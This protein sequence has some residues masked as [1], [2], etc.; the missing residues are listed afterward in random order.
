MVDGRAQEPPAEDHP[1][2]S[3]AV[4]ALA[5]HPSRAGWPQLLPA[6][7]LIGVPS[8]AAVY[9][10]TRLWN[11]DITWFDLILS[12]VM[13]VLTGLGITLGFHRMLAHGS[14]H[15]RRWLKVVLT[16]AGTMALQGAPISWV[17]QHRKH[18]V[19]SDRPGDPHSPSIA[20]NCTTKRWK[21]FCHSH[22]GWLFRGHLDEPERWSRDLI[23]DRDIKLISALT[24]LWFAASLAL[25][26]GIGYGVT[27]TLRGA[28]LAG[29]W[30]GLVRVFVLHHVTWSINSI[31]HVFGKRPFSTTDNSTNF[32]PLALLSFGESWHNAH[33]A[34]PGLARHGVDKGQV[35]PSAVVL[36][37]F[38]RIGWIT[39]VKWPRRELLAIRRVADPRLEVARFV[40]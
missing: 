14:F 40:R 2:A 9:G 31:C 33:H 5:L 38:E 1:S 10:L 15:P 8:L 30:A 22:A 23:A 24:P 25:P 29:L 27:R 34:F 6:A 19:F 36:R 21:S 11:R 17:S 35:D 13:Y 32:A 16:I 26:L 7:L 39:E 12:V 4:D 20:A 18:H 37:I 3:A 28:L